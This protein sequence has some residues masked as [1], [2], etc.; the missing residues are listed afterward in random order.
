MPRPVLHVFN[1]SHYCE[2]ARWALEAC[3]IDFELRHLMV[4]AHRRIAAERGARV[5]TLPFLWTTAG[6]VSGSAAIVDWCE[7]ASLASP[8]PWKTGETDDTRALER[9]LDDVVG[10]HVRRFYYSD[11]LFSMPAAVRPLF[12]QGLPWWQGFIV[13]L[14]WSRI[15]PIMR[16][17]MD[18]GPAQG[19]ESRAALLRELDWLDGLL[20]DGR[21]YLCGEHWSRA[22]LAAA[23]LLAPLVAPPTHP[24]LQMVAFP[25]QVRAA[26]AEW[27]PRP[28]LRHV[29]QCYARHRVAPVDAN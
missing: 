6:C 26:M 23:S 18:L 10:V 5:G 13:R 28:I 17:G 29:A 9:R 21:P 16:K 20:A 27:A 1:I 14:G 2:K 24:I 22:D 3:G 11:A 7:A 25:A 19:L 4:G 15:V 12:S 8:A